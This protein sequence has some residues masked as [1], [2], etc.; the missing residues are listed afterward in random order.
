MRLNQRRF[1]MSTEG[2]SQQGFSQGA[3]SQQSFTTVRTESLS[4]GPALGATRP[5]Y[6]DSTKG[7]NWLEY[8]RSLVIK[9]RRSSELEERLKKR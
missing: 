3:L 9:P 6:G 7:M 5:G 4:H 8:N 1:I 2:L